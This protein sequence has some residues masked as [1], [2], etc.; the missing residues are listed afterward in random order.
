MDLGKLEGE[1][2]SLTNF[3]QVK[4]KVNV[5]LKGGKILVDAEDLSPQD[6]KRWV[7][8]FVYSHNLMNKYWVGQEKNIVKINEFKR[9][10]KRGKRKER[11]TRPSTIKHGW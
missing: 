1:K 2:E 8:K 7:N 5:T 10:Q 6:L 4:L 11:G 3:L 9:I